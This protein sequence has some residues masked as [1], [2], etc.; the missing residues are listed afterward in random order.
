MVK[1]IFRIVIGLVAAV[2]L[3]AAAGLG[4]RAWRQDQAEG[5][6]VLAGPDAVDEAKFVTV[7]GTEQWITVR[8]QDRNN[9]VLL[10][11]HGGPGAALS[12]LA[13]AFL[14]FERDYV[15]VQWD[16]QGA[17]RTFTRAGR[18]IPG[19]LTSD[20]L[21][22]DGVA[23]AETV[24][25]ELGKDRLILVGASWGSMIAAR[26][27]RER[28][29]LFYAFVGTGQA[30]H[31]DDGRIAAYRLLLERARSDRNAGAVADLERIG[32]PP[33][34]DEESA[35]LQN[36]WM[37]AYSP[38]AASP[39]ARIGAVLLTPRT[40]LSDVRDYFGA[41]M[42]SDEHFDTGLIDLRQ[43]S[44][45]YALPV[46]IIQGTDDFSTPE[47]LARAYFDSLDAPEKMF[48]PVQG[49]GHTLLV[50]RTDAFVAIL[51]ERV[52]P[53]ATTPTGG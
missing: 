26:M 50:D 5:L 38:D 37:D 14:P 45:A 15:V 36:S 4:Y 39:L 20:D 29:D 6:L 52:R 49:G 42:A 13:L 1:W 17:G 22:Q 11:V 41:F 47:S 30:V 53:L 8:G 9:P 23:V 25:R 19:D 43:E 31:R 28:P 35:R 44:N 16:Q 7:R 33:Y 18:Q 2:L 40:S 3:L 21:V 10:I 27:A 51:N 12:P 48:I 32:P 34:S 24:R 46:F